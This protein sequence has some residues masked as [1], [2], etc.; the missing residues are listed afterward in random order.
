MLAR[1]MRLQASIRSGVKYIKAF[2][3]L[4]LGKVHIPTFK[5]KQIKMLQLAGQTEIQFRKN[6]LLVTS[7]QL[8]L[9]VI[10]SGNKKILTW[11]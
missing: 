1:G 5:I 2:S 7:F 10:A 4:K 9:L 11:L 8:H 6:K 3:K